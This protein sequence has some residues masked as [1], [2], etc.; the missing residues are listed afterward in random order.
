MATYTINTTTG[1]EALL[2]WLVDQNNQQKDLSLTNA[3]FLQA[4]FAEML[5]PYAASFQ[6]AVLK[7][8]STKFNAADSA[9]QAQVKILLGIP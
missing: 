9:T 6:E 1:Q 2:T 7:Q 8:V 3:Q 5:Q 4:K